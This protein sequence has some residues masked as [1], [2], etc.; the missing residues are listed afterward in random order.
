MNAGAAARSKQ[1]IFKLVAE[2]AVSALSHAESRIRIQ[3]GETLGALCAAKG[4]VVFTDFAQEALMSGIRDNMERD[5][6]GQCVLQRERA[7]S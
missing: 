3:A 4:S 5:T 2:T 6:Q 1:A 7:G